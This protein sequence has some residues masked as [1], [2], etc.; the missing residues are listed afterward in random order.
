[1]RAKFLTRLISL[2]I[3]ALT[4]IVAVSA[5]LLVFDVPNMCNDGKRCRMRHLIH[6]VLRQVIGPCHDLTS[7]SK[8]TQTSPGQYIFN[9]CLSTEEETCLTIA[10][11]SWK[12]VVERLASKCL[13]KSKVKFWSPDMAD[14]FTALLYF[15]FAYTFTYLPSRQPISSIICGRVQKNGC[16]IS[17]NTL[18]E[19]GN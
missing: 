1:M 10:R 17:D 19:E 14:C 2:N 4:N 15:P 13:G 6:A 8:D 11:Y 5:L 16:T 7:F 18:L 9:R 3:F 12:E